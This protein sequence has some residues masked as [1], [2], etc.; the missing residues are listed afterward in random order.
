[1]ARDNRLGPYLDEWN[2]KSE[3]GLNRVTLDRLSSE[4]IFSVNEELEATSSLR[5]GRY[6][7]GLHSE[8]RDLVV[9]ERRPIDRAIHE[10]FF[11]TDMEYWVNNHVRWMP[12]YRH[13]VVVR[14][15]IT[16]KDNLS[17]TVSP[18]C[19]SEHGE[20]DRAREWKSDPFL[21]SGGFR[22]RPMN[23][24]LFLR[25]ISHL[26]YHGHRRA[27]ESDVRRSAEARA[28][29]VAFWL[30]MHRLSSVFEI[31]Y[32][33]YIAGLTR[34]E[35]SWSSGN[36]HL[37]GLEIVDALS[38]YRSILAGKVASFKRSTGFAPEDFYAICEKAGRGGYEAL[39]KSIRGSRA[40]G[41]DLV[42]S[43]I[44]DLHAFLKKAKSYGI[45]QPET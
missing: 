31:H 25:D 27:S 33:N 16:T 9:G 14:A 1:M 19:L 29:L 5:R 35:I 40:V 11:H 6:S 26:F 45:W 10:M 39:S 30:A 43:V 3:D 20:W 24:A 36:E 37:V 34:E 18:E 28:V 17:V 41:I 44:R 8:Y 12:T 4:T 42:P 13:R 7:S 22:E 23:E 2:S 38:E 15:H 32:G 21:G